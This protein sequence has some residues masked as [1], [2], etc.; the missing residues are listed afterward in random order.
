MNDEK[1]WN[2][3]YKKRYNNYDLLRIISCIAIIIIHV[4]A[5]YKNLLIANVYNNTDTLY[6]ISVLMW[7]TLSRFAVPCFVMLSGAFLL[8]NDKN[9][10]YKEFYKKSFKKI[11]LPTIVFSILFFLCSVGKNIALIIFK[12]K[13]ISILI[14]PIKN[15]IERNAVL[16][17]MVFIH[18]NW[19]L[20]INTY[21]NKI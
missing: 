18:D 14:T 5:T 4:S 16:S 19:N 9:Q 3:G 15:A 17:F 20:F 21:S 11:G 1:Y 8:S 6:I 2:E 7:N 10:E 13:E 12:N